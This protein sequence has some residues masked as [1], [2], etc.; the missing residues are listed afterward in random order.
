[1]VSAFPAF[2]S[3]LARVSPAKMRR[4]LSAC[5]PLRLLWCSLLPVVVWMCV[6]LFPNRSHAGDPE[7]LWRTIE[8]E[9]FRITYHQPLDR[10]AQRLAQVAEYSHSVLSPVLKH[11]PRFRTEV[12]LTDDT[13]YSN[14]SA[15][16]LP[17][18]TVRVYLTAPDDRSELNDFDDWLYALFVHEY[19]HILHLDKMGGLPKWVN[20][21]LG[22]GINNVYAPNQVQPR[23][24]IEGL[25]V[26][27]ETERSSAG[28]LRSS[29]FDMYLRSHVLEDK[30]LRLDQVAN[31]TRLWPRGNVPYLYGSAFLRFLMKRFGHEPLAKVVAKY[32]G[33]WSPDCWVPWGMNRSLRAVTGQAYGPLY[34]E[35]EKD[36][37]K[38]YTAQVDGLLRSPLGITHG[39]PLT[40]WKVSVDRPVFVDGGKGLLV[41]ESDPY[42]RPA[43]V[44][45]DLQTGK[46]RREV[47]VDGAGG[48]A[49]SPNEKFVVFARLNYYRAIFS[50]Q[51]LYLYRRDRKELV[52]LSSGLRVDNPA[53]SP[54][55]KRVAFETTT[56]GT[57]RLG[58]ME[59]PFTDSSDDLDRVNPKAFAVP[60]VWRAKAARPVE[61]PLSQK[62]WSQA[63]TPNWSPDGKTLV[64]SYWQQ[65]GFRDIVT[66]D[67]ETRELRFVTR[68][69]ALDLEPRYSQD[70][71]WIYFVSDRTGIYNLYA[72][73]IDTGIT[74][75]LSN[76][77]HGVFSPDVSSDGKT[78]AVVGFVA[79]GYRIETFDLD[80]EHA[81]LAPAPPSDRPAPTFVGDPER[82]REP[83]Y[84]IKR[85]NPAR[86]FFRVP[87]SLLSAQLPISSPG[88]YGQAFGLQFSTADLTGNHS[89][90]GGVTFQ[91]N[92]LDATGFVARYTYGRLWNPINLDVSRSLSLRSGLRLNGKNRS[93]D[94]ETWQ[95]ALS[96][97][98]PILRDVM[99]A[100]T[101]SFAYNFTYWR[102]KTPVPTPGPDDISLRLPEV[103]RYATLSMTISYGDT[104]RFIFSVGPEQGGSVYVN[105]SIANPM[106]GSD[107][108]V[109][110]VRF[111]ATRNFGIPWPSKYLRN[112]TLMLSYEGGLS[113]G[114]LKRRGVYYVGGFPESE[115]YLRAALF[116]ARPG[117]PRLRG[118]EYSATYGDQ[119]HVA[120]I[121]YRFPLLWLER[122][123]DTLP[124]Y[125]WRLH[126]AIYSDVGG[127]FF[128][129]FSF[130]KIKA[131]IGAELRLDGSLG[132]Y[133]PFMLQLGYA[134]GFMEGAQNGFYFLLNNPL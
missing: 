126:G 26:L 55:G 127:A 30:F 114:D 122:G 129:P 10:A 96:T 103:G 6:F 133:L 107:F 73:H 74:V 2:P 13:D 8:T 47:E 79:E 121:E 71:K 101:L 130:E 64:F 65:G 102:N 40:D 19:T 49:V 1:M 123:Y 57:R 92:R 119:Y 46:T 81:P 38:R 86:T 104:R 118:Y 11:A 53:I 112:H 45:V 82:T 23:W 109:Y 50:F 20:L 42:R 7:L 48:L 9:H 80:L 128:G 115:D 25:A 113:G 16:A 116:G 28:R 24:F 106:L 43:L 97:S 62:E 117:Q 105:A 33:C 58:I 37:R 120:N 68:D 90:S 36:L 108:Q 21:L 41:L 3:C 18:P 22:L 63:Y 93:Y 111:A 78:A 70:G 12:L 51:D 87:A 60:Q 61:F 132:Y 125:L 110:N 66:L 77:T 99:R 69:R 134:H 95:G 31:Q 54:D 14:G 4:A 85:Y 72:H 17:F 89:L 39:M 75:Q 32:G 100:A 59:L 131:S 67:L 83:L 76:V 88:P 34:Q 56:A 29:L 15:T 35:F 27:E 98:L 91:A 5:T 44:H 52:A 124:F 94:E 84:P